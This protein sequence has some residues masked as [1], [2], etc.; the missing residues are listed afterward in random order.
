VLHRTG[1][2][3]P[4]PFNLSRNN[5][6]HPTPQTLKHLRTFN[7]TLI[8]GVTHTWPFLISLSTDR[9][10]QFTTHHLYLNCKAHRPI[11]FWPSHDNIQAIAII[12]HVFSDLIHGLFPKTPSQSTWHL[13]VF[14]LHHVSSDRD[15]LCISW[16]ASQR[17]LTSDR[18]Q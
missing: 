7:A 14:V 4:T 12:S 3:A 6:Y 16:R 17:I 13:Q 2:L 10:I 9:T 8:T 5:L 1:V 11:P 15:K 18:L